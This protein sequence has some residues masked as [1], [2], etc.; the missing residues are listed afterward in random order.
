MNSRLSDLLESAI[1]FASLLGGFMAFGSGMLAAGSLI[2]TAS[3][4]VFSYRV[5]VGLGWGFLVGMPFAL[6]AF[7]LNLA[8]EL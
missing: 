3:A 4:E 7:F 6:F 5:N 1:I 8:G 2:R